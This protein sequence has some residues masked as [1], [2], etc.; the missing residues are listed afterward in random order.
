MNH[1]GAARFSVGEDMKEK[2]L[3]IHAGSLN[4]LYKGYNDQ[5]KFLTCRWENE[6]LFLVN[7]QKVL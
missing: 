5:F 4:I 3:K 1:F 2:F 6:N 7:F